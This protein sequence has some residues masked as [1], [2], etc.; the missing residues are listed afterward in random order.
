MTIA[1]PQFRV[2]SP[3]QLRVHSPAMDAQNM[4]VACTGCCGM[5]ITTVR[6]AVRSL[7][8]RV[9]LLEGDGGAAAEARPPTH[10]V[11]GVNAKRTL[12]ALAGI[13]RGAFLVTPEWCTASALAGV[14]L[15]PCSFES[16]RF[17]GAARSR[18]ARLCPSKLRVRDP[19]AGMRVAVAAGVSRPRAMLLKLARALGAEAYAGGA[20][21]CDVFVAQ[22]GA[23]RPPA[24]P[25]AAGFV[26]EEWLLHSV[27]TY[28]KAPF[29]AF[30]P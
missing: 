16:A 18:A 2:A 24:L 3:L 28:Q 4:V 27:E 14:W 8:P 15:D 29:E 9:V 10:I 22:R 25:V 13:T 23:A 11:V 26:E 1:A 7:R 17:P 6:N 12:K 30:A 21:R 5:E 20:A 19:L